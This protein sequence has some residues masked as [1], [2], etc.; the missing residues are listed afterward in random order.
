MKLEIK[1]R[2]G[3]RLEVPDI[4]L[5]DICGLLTKQFC[6]TIATSITRSEKYC[7]WASKDGGGVSDLNGKNEQVTSL[8]TSLFKGEKGKG[9]TKLIKV[10]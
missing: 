8:Q 4:L 7:C 3:K 10:P 6:D 2:L 5:P 1:K 9:Q